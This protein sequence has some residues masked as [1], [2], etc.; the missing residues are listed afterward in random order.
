MKYSPGIRSRWYQ[1]LIRTLYT[2]AFNL[3]LACRGIGITP[4]ITLHSFVHVIS[5][6]CRPILPHRRILPSTLSKQD[7]AKRNNDVATQPTPPSSPSLLLRANFAAKH[8]CEY[9][10]L[11]LYSLFRVF[12]ER[13]NERKF[14]SI[15]FAQLN[16]SNRSN[17]AVNRRRRRIFTRH[18]RGKRWKR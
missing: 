15:F 5:P 16:L 13:T 17:N 6:P 3:L 2:G 7:N 10:F 8:R 9:S 14:E 12:A 4:D 11:S 18:S 1:A